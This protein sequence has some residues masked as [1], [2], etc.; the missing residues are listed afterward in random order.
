MGRYCR[1]DRRTGPERLGEAE[2]Y[3]GSAA[4]VAG[5]AF[6]EQQDDG[7]SLPVAGGVDR[8][9]GVR[10]VRLAH[11]AAWGLGGTPR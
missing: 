9:Y 2:E 4:M 1:P 8:F 3:Q 11:N 6:G 10:S 5:L 7:S